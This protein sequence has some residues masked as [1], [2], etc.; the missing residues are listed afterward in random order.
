MAALEPELSG[1]EPELS[2]LETELGGLDLRPYKC[3]YVSYG[4]KQH[5]GRFRQDCPP[6]LSLLEEGGFT[7]LV[8]IAIDPSFTFTVEERSVPYRDDDKKYMHITVPTKDIAH[9][10]RITDQLVEKLKENTLNACFFVNFIKFKNPNAREDTILK[11]AMEIKYHIPYDYYDWGGFNYPDFIIKT[12]VNGEICCKDVTALLE[13]ELY[14]GGK[15]SKLFIP[16][17]ENDDTIKSYLATRQALYE[18]IKNCLINIASYITH[19][20]LLN[21]F[22]PESGGTRKRKSKRTKRKSKR[23]HVRY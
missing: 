4:S 17:L 22:F 6:F 12:A 2:G 8:C 19:T 16:A 20:Y 11:D 9:T 3:V 18:S 7:P 14:K 21:R 1:L 10:I 5:E 15:L 23:K 13:N